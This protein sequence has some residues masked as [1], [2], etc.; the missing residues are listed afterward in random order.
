MEHDYD[1][2]RQAQAAMQ[3]AASADPLERQPLI[4]LALAWQELARATFVDREVRPIP[5]GCSRRSVEDGES[6]PIGRRERGS[7]F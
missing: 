4:R 5:R 1:P 2:E 7:T 6:S 3:Q